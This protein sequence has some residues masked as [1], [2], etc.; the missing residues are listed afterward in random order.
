MTNDNA[1]SATNT[2][3]PALLA[4]IQEVQNRAHR[5]AEALEAVNFME[6]QGGCDSGRYAVS[7]IAQDLAEEIAIKLDSINLPGATA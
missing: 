6:N 7:M 2:G 1:D 3:L 4:Y 5:L